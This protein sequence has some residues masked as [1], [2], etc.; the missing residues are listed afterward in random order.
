M[1]AIPHGVYILYS[2][3]YWNIFTGLIVYS[4]NGFP[5]DEWN[6]FAWNISSVYNNLNGV[7]WAPFY[8]AI[9]RENYNAAEGSPA[10][11][12]GDDWNDHFVTACS[13]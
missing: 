3:W 8:D 7:P 10:P 12:V 9:R 5:G 11:Y 4:P 1:M 6:S 2:Q 13:C